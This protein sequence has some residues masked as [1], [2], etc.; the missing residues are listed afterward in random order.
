M[1][2][3]LTEKNLKVSVEFKAK[4]QGD[5]QQVNLAYPVGGLVDYLKPNLTGT[6]ITLSKI[7]PTGDPVNFDDLE[8]KITQSAHPDNDFQM[9]TFSSQTDIPSSVKSKT[10]NAGKS[11]AGDANPSKKTGDVGVGSDVPI[12]AGVQTSGYLLQANP[13]D[14]PSFEGQ[15]ACEVCT[16]LNAAENVVC[17]M[18]NTA[19]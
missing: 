18:C 12:A 5:G 8:I 6:L 2:T 16:F 10:H 7:D 14:M 11:Q 9:N 1:L 19:F 3:N 4:K 17:E 15:K 13:D